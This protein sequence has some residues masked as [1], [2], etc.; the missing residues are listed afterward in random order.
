MRHWEKIIVFNKQT[1][2]ETMRIIDKTALQ[3]AVVLDEQRRLLG[4]VTDGDIRR[5]I[6]RGNGLEVPITSIMNPNPISA[7]EGQKNYKYHK[8]MKSKMLKQLPIVDR[9][10]R[11]IDIIFF[12]SVD[13]LS[14]KNTVVLMLGGLGTRLRPLTDDTP[15][16]MLRVGNKPILETIVE[17]FK[18]YGYSNF[19]FS[20]NYKKEVIKDYF[21]NG[22]HF[23]ISIDYVEE[24]TRMGTAGALSLIKNRPS[25]PFF[26]MNGDLLT[27]INFDQLMEFHQEQN[28]VATMCVREYEFQIPYGVIE[29]SGTRLVT[30]K[31][32]PVHRSFVNAGIYV[33]SPEVFNYIPANTFYDMPTLFE[34]L[35]EA[36]LK[37]T[38]FPIHEYWLDIG[39]MD[40]YE[41]ADTEY[42]KIF[43]R[44]VLR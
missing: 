29:T 14:N 16:P 7:R 18:Q 17:S 44:E 25:K 12:D 11:I 3:F 40:E 31:E 2:F 37:T 34:Q 10:N 41:R 24:D 26:V 6:L 13:R 1:L 5:G 42:M 21:Q 30:I 43:K 22:E 32:K 35:I 28:S 36:G 39:K 23:D 20:V 15:K 9:E 38:V 19:I 33:L 8:I 27:Q 4:T